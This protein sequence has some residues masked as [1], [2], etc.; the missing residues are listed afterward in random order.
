MPAAHLPSSPRIAA[1]FDLGDHA[2]RFM[3]KV[4]Q[5]YHTER[6]GMCLLAAMRRFVRDGRRIILTATSFCPRRRGA[7]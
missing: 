1:R 2:G 5:R 3:L 7:R 4:L 6:M